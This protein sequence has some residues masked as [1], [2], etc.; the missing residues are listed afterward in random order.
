MSNICRIRKRYSEADYAM[1]G[2]PRLL[3]V[4]EACQVFGISRQTFCLWR[5][6]GLK[7]NSLYPIM[8]SLKRIIEWTRKQQ[9]L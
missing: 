2:P 5:K 9:S 1:M 7:A 8:V 6:R 4:T 3:D